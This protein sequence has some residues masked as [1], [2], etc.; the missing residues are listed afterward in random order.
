MA[1]HNELGKRGEAAAAAFLAGKG[2]AIRHRNWRSDGGELDI[3][4]EY[5]GE[6]VVVEVKTRRGRWFGNPEEAVTGRKIRRIVR[7]TD[8]YV[9]RHGVD[10]PV[11]FDIIAVVGRE[12]PFHI[13]HWEKAF[14][15]PV[16]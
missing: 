7:A 15:P 10:L 12:P 9:K 13:E 4:A 5:G 1:E 8:R 6:L 16:W 2:Y 11:R 3:V 14:L